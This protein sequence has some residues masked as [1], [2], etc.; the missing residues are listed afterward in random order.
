[1]HFVGKGPVK[2]C[3][4]KK[5]DLLVKKKGNVILQWYQGTSLKGMVLNQSDKQWQC[6][7]EVFQN[8]CSN[9]HHRVMFSAVQPESLKGVGIDWY[10]SLTITCIH[11][12]WFF[13]AFEAIFKAMNCRFTQS[14]TF[15]HSYLWRA[16]VFWGFLCRSLNIFL[17]PK[18]KR[19]YTC[20]M[21][22]LIIAQLL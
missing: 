6:F 1:M 8:P 13:K 11:L 2:S 15:S 16:L 12:P 14:L 22:Y 4:P 9:I 19:F 21:F 3:R 17:L 5:T 20:G 10:S 7:S 18:K